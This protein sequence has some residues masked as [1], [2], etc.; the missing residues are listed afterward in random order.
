MNSTCHFCLKPDVK[1]FFADV[2][3][4][5]GT[6]EPVGLLESTA[7]FVDFSIYSDYSCFSQYKLDVTGEGKSEFPYD[8]AI[9]MGFSV[10]VDSRFN[11]DDL[12]SFRVRFYSNTGNPSKL[13]ANIYAAYSRNYD[14]L[15]QV[16]CQ[17]KNFRRDIYTGPI[18]WSTGPWEVGKTYMTPNLKDVVQPFFSAGKNEKDW[19]WRRFFFI[20]FEWITT[21]GNSLRI[22]TLQQPN[23]IIQYIDRRPGNQTSFTLNCPLQFNFVKFSTHSSFI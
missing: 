2:R 21:R 23:Y 9:V 22:R 12:K 7:F 3:I 14:G 4:F 5:F 19:N 8:V 13:K 16:S 18:A 17:S 20:I 11:Y 6:G 10:R 15:Y 1:T